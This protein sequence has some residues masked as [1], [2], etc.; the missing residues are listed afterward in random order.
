MDAGET[1]DQYDGAPAGSLRRRVLTAVR[2][3]AWQCVGAVL[4]VVGVVV[5]FCSSPATAG[6]PGRRRRRRGSRRR[7]PGTATPSVPAI[8]SPVDTDTMGAE[9]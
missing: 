9:A 5:T 2:D 3:P 7:C 4:A 8:R 1:G 6:R